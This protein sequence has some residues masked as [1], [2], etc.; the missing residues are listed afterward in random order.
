MPE[1]Q[2]GAGGRQLLDGTGRSRHARIALRRV[3]ARPRPQS[4]R[5]LGWRDIETPCASLSTRS[6]SQPR[7]KPGFSTRGS[8]G[9]EVCTTHRRAFARDGTRA[10]PGVIGLGPDGPQP[11]DY[12]DAPP[13]MATSA[14]VAKFGCKLVALRLK[15]VA[16]DDPRSLCDE[17]ASL[18]CA[19][20]ARSSTDKYDFPFETIPFV[21]YLVE[22][23][24]YCISS[25]ALA[26]RATTIF[27]GT[28]A[29]AA[30]LALLT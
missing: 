24:W 10:P 4:E 12:S 1:R 19:L 27:S 7:G 26:G 23:C 16:N 18:G 21:L 14:P 2:G 15:H 22:Q 6:P 25:D 8:W 5:R 13:S 11:A 20:S 9:L 28:P 3:A 29:L 17:Q 30:C